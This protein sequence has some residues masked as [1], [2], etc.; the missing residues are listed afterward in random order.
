[1]WVKEPAKLVKNKKGPTPPRVSPSA[2][3]C[4]RIRA[5][6]KQVSPLPPFLLKV[7]R[8][9]AEFFFG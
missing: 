8:K 7:I 1:M 6:E 2:V 3:W 5:A 9:L 4:H